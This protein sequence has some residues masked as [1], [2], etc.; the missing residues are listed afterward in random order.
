MP[1]ATDHAC[2]L[3]VLLWILCLAPGWYQGVSAELCSVIVLAHA[4]YTSH[5]SYLPAD[6]MRCL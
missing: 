6:G 3:C 1:A 4:W 5:S 2:G